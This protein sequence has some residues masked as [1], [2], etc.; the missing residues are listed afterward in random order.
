MKHFTTGELAGRWNVPGWRLR[1]VLRAMMPDG[2][3]A[4][5]YRLV[6][7]DRLPD[8]KAALQQHGYT[9]PTDGSES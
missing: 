6:P 4:G 5:R 9:L 3:K 8:V 2:P 7:D 1:R